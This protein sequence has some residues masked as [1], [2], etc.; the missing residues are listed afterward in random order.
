MIVAL[1]RT[2]FLGC[3]LGSGRRQLVALLGM[4]FR[5]LDVMM[6]RM[7]TVPVSQVCVVRRLF[8][9]LGLIVFRCLVVMVGRFLMMTRGVM[10][11]LPSL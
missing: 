3:L 7:L 2:L 11:M 8:V 4:Q 9:L 1:N 6:N 10:V 5:R